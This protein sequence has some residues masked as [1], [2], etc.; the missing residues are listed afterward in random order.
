MQIAVAYLSTVVAFTL[1]DLVWLGVVAKDFYRRQLG[2]L[3]ADRIDWGAG[4]AF[5]AIFAAG[6]VIFAVAPALAT[7][8]VPRALGLGLLFGFFAYATYDLTN[9]ATLRGFPL[10]LA[11]VDMVWGAALTG[12]AAALATAVTLRLTS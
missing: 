7:G 4:L 1:I 11:L 10:R 9:L 12:T 6:I 2:P 5:Y 3:M 8:G